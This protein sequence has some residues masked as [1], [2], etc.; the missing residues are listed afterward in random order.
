MDQLK[1]TTE[2]EAAVKMNDVSAYMQVKGISHRSMVELMRTR[3]PRFDSP[4]LSKCRRPDLYGVVLHPDGFKL[5]GEYPDRRPENRKL[6][7]RI[8]GRLTDDEYRKLVA[9]IEKDGY[10][11]IQDFVRDKV[12]EYLVIAETVL[13]RVD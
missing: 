7:R 9:Y 13:G 10:K 2:L 5:L 3:F 1:L 6:K 11:S 4:L 8:Y 12:Q